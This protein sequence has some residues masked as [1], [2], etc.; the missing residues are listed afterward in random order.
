M[1]A[2]QYEARRSLI[3]GHTE[4]TTYTIDLLLTVCDRKRDTERK[5]QRAMSGKTFTLYQRGDVVWNCETIP[6][7][8]TAADQIREFL[9]SV[10]DGQVFYFD[11]LNWAGTSPND[12]RAVVITTDGYTENRYTQRGAP[13]SDHF[14]FRFS[15]HEQP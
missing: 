10:E 7:T 1:Q 3:S 14:K 6:V 15:F 11:P 13:A 4:G 12:F 2:V 5:Q 9:D 8:G